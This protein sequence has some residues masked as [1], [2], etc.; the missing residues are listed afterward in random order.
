[1][2][3]DNVIEARS[4]QSH[5]SSNSGLP[6]GLPWMA[7]PCA[8][9]YSSDSG[10][11]GHSQ[12]SLKVSNWEWHVSLPLKHCEVCHTDT[13]LDLNSYYQVGT[14]TSDYLQIRFYRSRKA[15]AI[16]SAA[17]PCARKDEQN[18]QGAVPVSHR[19]Q[20]THRI[21]CNLCFDFF[22]F[23]NRKRPNNIF[24]G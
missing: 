23:F 24:A 16:G 22:F 8:C 13:E 17:L 10:E 9:S 20:H 18:W 15:K 14:L 1:M 11:G 2:I 4:F 5:H 21:W 19:N 3:V 6:S 12:C 7:E